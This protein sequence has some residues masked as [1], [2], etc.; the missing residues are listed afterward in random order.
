MA[1]WKEAEEKK[2]RQCGVDEKTIKQLRI[3]DWAVF[4]SDRRFYEK[5]QEVGS[6]LDDVVESEQHT[7]I[8]TVDDFLNSIENEELLQIL[9]TVDRLTLQAVLMKTQGYT[10]R[11]AASELQLSE[12]A[13]YNRIGRLRRKIKNIF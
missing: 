10:Y 3:E 4:N 2:L 7:E 5:L 6:Y 12:D 1:I 13:L 9:L 11:E 8:S